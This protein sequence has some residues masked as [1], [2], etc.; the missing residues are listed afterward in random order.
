VRPADVRDGRPYGGGGCG[1]VGRSR[2][3]TGTNVSRALSRIGA[4][5]STGPEPDKILATMRLL[6]PAR[7]YVVAGYPPFLRTLLDEAAR[8]GMDLSAYR[9]HGF[10][11]G[12]GMSEALRTRLEVTFRSVYSAYGASDLDIGVAAETPMSVWVRRRAAAN[13]DLAARLFGMTGRL[14]MV[15]Q[16]DPTDYHVE[17]IAASSSSPSAGRRCSHRASATT[18]MTPGAPSPSPG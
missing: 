6:G 14:P 11:G 8:C 5:K 10:V 17:A 9:L 18:F 12:E 7:T 15:F 4:V 2:R 13:P 3:A 16:Y 1:P